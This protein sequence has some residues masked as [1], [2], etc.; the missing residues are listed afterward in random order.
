[1]VR[2]FQVITPH[3]DFVD[4]ARLFAFVPDNLR[5]LLGVEWRSAGAR[6]RRGG[7]RYVTDQFQSRLDALGQIR[8]F[9]HPVHMHVVNPRL[10]PEKMIVKGGNVDAIV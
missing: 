10:I 1:M 4:R 9:P 8:R 7:C 3:S 5:E 6:W 2:D